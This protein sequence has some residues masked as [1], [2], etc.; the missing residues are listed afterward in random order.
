MYFVQTV[1]DLGSKIDLFFVPFLL[2][3]KGDYVN[4]K[5]YFLSQFVYGTLV[6]LLCQGN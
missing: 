6:A 1:I 5:R 2:L 4:K 3:N